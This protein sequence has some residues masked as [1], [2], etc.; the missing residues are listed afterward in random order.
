M[1]NIGGESAKSNEL[2][3]VLDRTAPTGVT[4]RVT[5]GK[6]STVNSIPVTATGKDEQSRN[7]LIHIL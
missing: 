7:I 4:L 6:N 2:K 3:V 5:S 1:K